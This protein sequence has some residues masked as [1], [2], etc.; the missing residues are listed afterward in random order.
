MVGA[1]RER[2][3][4]AEQEKRSGRQ[5]IHQGR[6]RG[7][8]SRRPLLVFEVSLQDSNL[9]CRRQRDRGN[10]FARNLRERIEVTKRFQFVSEKFQPHR[11]RMGGGINVENAAAQSDF[12]FLRDLRLRFVTLFFKPLDQIERLEPVA[13][14]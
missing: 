7:G 14:L 9:T 3:R 8:C 12:A 5:V 10:F 13:P 4:F 1:F 11:P 6:R 2:V